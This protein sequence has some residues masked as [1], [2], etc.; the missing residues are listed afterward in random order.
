MEHSACVLISDEDSFFKNNCKCFFSRNQIRVLCLGNDGRKVL[1]TI[2]NDKPDVVV[3]NA[4]MPFFDAASVIHIANENRASASQFIVLSDIEDIELKRENIEAGARDY[5]L[6]PFDNTLLFSKILHLI[7]C[8]KSSD[9]KGVLAKFC[10]KDLPKVPYADLEPL[11]TNII[12][13]FGIPPSIK[14]CAYLKEAV[15]FVFDKFSFNV[16]VT[17]DIYPAIAHSHNSTPSCVER[18]IRHAIATAWPKISRAMANNLI[19]PSF[20]M[21][22]TNSQFIYYIV[23]ELSMT[24]QKIV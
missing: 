10:A 6:K 23:N 5:L 14:G 3:L 7:S 17:K 20:I 24:D 1:S 15:L 11:V 9:R 22:P 2:K 4:V 18:A 13:N 21:R 16:S 19:P 8:A 12:L